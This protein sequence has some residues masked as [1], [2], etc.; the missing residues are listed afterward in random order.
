M[1]FTQDGSCECTK[2]ELDLFLVPPTQ[3]ST[4]SA[5]FVEYHPLS[6]LSD[7]APIEFEVG[8]SGEDYIDLN[9]SQFFVRLID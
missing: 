7:G 2:S 6:S 5:S 1:A 4:E 9:D 8:P 3:I